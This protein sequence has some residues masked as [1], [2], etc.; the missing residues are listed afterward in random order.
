MDI[1]V[2]KFK[3]F[4]LLMIVIIFSACGF[5]KV[6]KGD[7]IRIGVA[8]DTYEDKFHLTILEGL[9]EAAR[10][11]DYKI[12]LTFLDAE[13]NMENQITQVKKFIDKKMDAVIVLPVNSEEAGPISNICLDAKMK[14]VYVN[15]KPEKIP[16]GI[17]YVGPEEYEEGRIQLEYAA[18]KLNKSGKIGILVGQL[19]H[20]AAIRRTEGIEEALVKYPDIKV[21]KKQ[22]AQFNREMAKYVVGNWLDSGVELDAIL[23][24]NDEMAIGAI[25]ALEERGLI[26]KIYVFGV[27]GTDSGILE[28]QK[29]NLDATIFQNGKAQGEV[30]IKVALDLIEKKKTE[31]EILVGPELITIENYKEI[32]SE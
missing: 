6:E 22:T 18:E 27:D 2:K 32:L 29:G 16:E 4:F 12:E 8:L 10:L 9:K 3:L 1:S 25:R 5:N 28:L 23:A 15:I 17:P 21:V 11:S 24:N 30:A 31:K 19:N 7:T 13:R 14:L 26:N 20:H